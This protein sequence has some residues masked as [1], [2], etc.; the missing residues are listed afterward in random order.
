M[1]PMILVAMASSMCHPIDVV[2]VCQMEHSIALG[3]IIRGRDTHAVA[4]T[5][6][7]GGPVAVALVTV[8]STLTVGKMR[9]DG[10]VL[11]EGKCCSY[12][13]LSQL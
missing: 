8:V 11:M 5:V 10:P 9:V 4:V 13:I 1:G 2:A 7:A 3:L 6:S 12:V